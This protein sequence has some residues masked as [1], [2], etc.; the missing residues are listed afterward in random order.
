MDG[1]FATDIAITVERTP[2]ILTQTRITQLRRTITP[3]TP[4][5]DNERAAAE[6]RN[7]FT[8]HYVEIGIDQGIAQFR[9]LPD[10]RKN[11]NPLALALEKEL[12]TLKG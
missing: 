1:S 4:P 2:A 7:I 9:N 12:Y 11:R 10:E 6:F 3:Q 8:Q 5:A